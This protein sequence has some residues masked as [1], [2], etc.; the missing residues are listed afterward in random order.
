MIKAKQKRIARSDGGAF[1]RHLVF[2]SIIE[3]LRNETI[4][5]SGGRQ[6][7][8]LHSHTKATLLLEG[9]TEKDFEDLEVETMRDCTYFIHEK[10]M[11]HIFRDS[12]IGIDVPPVLHLQMLIDG[13]DPLLLVKHQI[14][15]IPNLEQ[16]IMV[17]KRILRVLTP[18]TLDRVDVFVQ[19]KNQFGDE[20]GDIIIDIDWRYSA[21]GFMVPCFSRKRLIYGLKVFRYPGDPRPFML[22]KRT[23]K[24][25]ARKS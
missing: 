12:E 10:G 20:T 4:R 24:L 2:R 18:K 19:E 3:E 23:N 16:N 14:I 15:P 13:D 17:S 1:G 22:R 9:W 11:E 5:F 21:Q 8:L 6:H 7:Y 25:L